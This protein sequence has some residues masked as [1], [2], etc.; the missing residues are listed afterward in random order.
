MTK[1]FFAIYRQNRW[2]YATFVPD[3]LR[4]QRASIIGQQE[5]RPIQRAW[6]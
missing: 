1:P 2:R 4:M 3:A 5:R 6:N